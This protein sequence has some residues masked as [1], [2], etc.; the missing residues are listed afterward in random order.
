MIAKTARKKVSQGPVEF[1]HAVLQFI[2]TR[3]YLWYS[4]RFCY[5][6]S[7]D[8][9]KMITI[10]PNELEYML[11][12]RRAYLPTTD[13]RVKKYGAPN[14]SPVVGVMGGPWDR[15]KKYWFDHTMTRSIRNRYEQNIPWKDTEY[16]RYWE[17]YASDGSKYDEIDKRVDDLD[18]LF[19]SLES[20]GYIPQTE[21]LDT[22]QNLMITENPSTV[23]IRGENYPSE[24]RIAIGRD[25]ELIRCDAAKHRVTMAKLIGIEKIPVIILIR[26]SR[27][28]Q[29]RDAYMSAESI[30]DVPPEYRKHQ[31]HPD[32][33]KITD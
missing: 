3:I 9:P 29:I 25:G 26:H 15:L 11:A 2:L 8:L 24:C 16:Y 4:L 14:N 28:Q 27:W 31:N 18:N 22:N 20:D 1:L 33:P 32:I 13:N 5:T 19:E 17:R 10:D 12:I 6:P 7:R 30:C 23:S 21:L